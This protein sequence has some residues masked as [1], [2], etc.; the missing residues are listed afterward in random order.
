MTTSFLAWL[1]R[2]RAQH[3]KARA[4][5]QVQIQQQH[6]DRMALQRRDRVGLAVDGA[7]QLHARHAQQRLA[8]PLGQHARILHQQHREIARTHASSSSNHAFIACIETSGRYSRRVNSR[9]ASPVQS[10]AAYS[11]P[12]YWMIPLRSA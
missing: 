10:D 8:Q 1:A 4:L 3:T 5:A 6:V 7:R 2:D 11:A 9:A 12:H